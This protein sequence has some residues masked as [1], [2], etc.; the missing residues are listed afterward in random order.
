MRAGQGWK[1]RGVVE[2][3]EEEATENEKIETAG[4]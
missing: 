2:G 3:G 4:C 1:D